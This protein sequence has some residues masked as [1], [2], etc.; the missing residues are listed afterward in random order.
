MKQ[1]TSFLVGAILILS[2]HLAKVN[3]VDSVY[4]DSLITHFS[5]PTTLLSN[6]KEMQ[7]WRM[8][9]A[10]T[11]PGMVNELKYANTLMTRFQAFG[12]IG[13][14]EKADSLV[15]AVNVRYRKT[16]TNNSI[17]LAGYAMLQHRFSLAQEYLNHARELGGRKY[18]MLLTAFD[19][20][21]ELGQY[22]S[23]A[24]VLQT[25]RTNKDFNYFFRLAKWQHL[26]GATDSALQSML[27]AAKY[28]EDDKYLRQVAL[29]NAGDLCVHTGMLDEAAKLYKQSLQLNSTDFHSLSGLGWLAM[30]NDGKRFAGRTHIQI[31][32]H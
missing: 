12:D 17:T 6:E 31:C 24:L 7:F 2:C 15:S 9:M 23:A 20:Y 25:T 4:V 26:N 18:A 30:V 21:F 27:I 14:L 1:F 28:A 19:V 11:R 32:T 16:E 3:I 13:D 10:N 5:T 22:D 29:A 8:K